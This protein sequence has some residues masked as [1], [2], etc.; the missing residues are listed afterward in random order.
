MQVIFYAKVEISLEISNEGGNLIVYMYRHTVSICL[1]L[2]YLLS[3]CSLSV[4]W[5]ANVGTIQ[6]TS[7]HDSNTKL[8][9]M[10]LFSQ[11][12]EQQSDNNDF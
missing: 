5:L 3:K 8:R 1:F 2:F 9:P 7:A 10:G 12:C 6:W 11:S 4:A